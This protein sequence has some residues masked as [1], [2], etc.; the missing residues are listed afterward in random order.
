LNDSDRI[1]AMFQSFGLRTRTGSAV[2]AGHHN[3][4][5][6]MPTV[7]SDVEQSEFRDVVAALPS[8][9]LD[10]FQREPYTQWE[11]SDVLRQRCASSMA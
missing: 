2:V 4:T 1:Q 6:G 11:W 7:V 10:I 8:S 3:R 5:P 9:Y